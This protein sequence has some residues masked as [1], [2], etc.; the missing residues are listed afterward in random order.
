[1]PT[2]E[3][4]DKMLDQAAKRRQHS[5][6]HIK[7]KFVFDLDQTCKSPWDSNKIFPH[8]STTDLYEKR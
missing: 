7:T 5:V 4:L 8:T 1:M 2:N 3:M 6:Q